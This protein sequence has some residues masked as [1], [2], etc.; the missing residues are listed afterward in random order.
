MEKISV[1]QVIFW[2]KKQENVLIKALICGPIKPVW[3]AGYVPALDIDEEKYFSCLFVQCWLS[4][5]MTFF[6]RFF[7]NAFRTF[8]LIF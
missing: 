2:F 1:L 5:K 7:L 6:S 4:H 8:P 3:V